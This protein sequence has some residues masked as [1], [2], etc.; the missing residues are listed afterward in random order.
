MA[1]I[2]LTETAYYSRKAIVYGAVG[3][4]ALSVTIFTWQLLSKALKRPP[5]PKPPTMGFGRL[6]T[7]QFPKQQAP[8]DFTFSLETPDGKLPSMPNQVKVFF[9][10]QPASGFLD[11]DAAK[12]KAEGLGFTG[13]PT[14]QNDTT[15]SWSASNGRSLTI[16]IVNGDLSYS[17]DPSANPDLYKNPQL[18]GPDAAAQT[19]KSFLTN[20]GSF[21]NDLSLGTT[22]YVYLKPSDNKLV[23]AISLSETQFILVGFQRRD[24]D[25]LSVLPA[26]PIRGAVWV[27]V[28]NSNDQNTKVMSAN[29]RFLAAD[30][31]RFE[32]YPTKPIA[33]AWK[34]LNSGNFFLAHVNEQHGNQITIRRVSLGYF[35]PQ[36]S[37]E[38]LEPIYV[39]EGD[40]DFTAYVP[41]LD[42]SSLA[43]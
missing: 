37:S 18:L 8:S 21:P 7:I 38:Y 28:T 34:E 2:S 43:P 27:L 30:P 6:P 3:L 19:A 42:P 35:D 29:Y 16:D 36:D 24:Y 14:K 39:F 15:Y 32:T 10:P 40:S 26:D 4:V 17:L 1:G 13:N 12:R 23:P 25:N 9:V 20:A 22:K 5:P 41:A 11:L 31:D 33:Q